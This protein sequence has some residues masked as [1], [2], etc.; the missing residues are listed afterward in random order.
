MSNYLKVF[1]LY[2]VTLIMGLGLCLGMFVGSSVRGKLNDGGV[3]KWDNLNGLKFEIYILH[4]N[5]TRKK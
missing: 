2:T 1:D 5:V 3:G 4:E